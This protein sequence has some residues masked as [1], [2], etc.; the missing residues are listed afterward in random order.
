MF[1]LSFKNNL[2]KK[3]QINNEKDNKR[4]SVRQIDAKSN[5]EKKDYTIDELKNQLSFKWHTL[6]I[7]K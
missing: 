4:I 1:R 2:I 5:E 3:K 7:K 6:S